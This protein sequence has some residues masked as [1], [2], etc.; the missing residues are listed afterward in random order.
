MGGSIFMWFRF[1]LTLVCSLQPLLIRLL[2]RPPLTARLGDE[3][4]ADELPDTLEKCFD[5]THIVVFISFYFC[6]SL[7]M[8]SLLQRCRVATRV[9]EARA[10]SEPM[11][12]RTQCHARMSIVEEEDEDSMLQLCL[13]R[14]NTTVGQY[15][16]YQ[17]SC[18]SDFRAF[19]SPTR[20]VQP[21]KRQHHAPKPPAASFLS[22]WLF[23]SREEI[24]LNASL[25]SYP[26]SLKYSL[27]L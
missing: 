23:S 26:F 1:L 14:R 6:L 3:Q 12:E 21:L 5:L 24:R 4:V 18:P 13:A 2:F 27:P 20:I 25:A 11:H 7:S 10:A 8:Q 15:I 16:A 9:N 19:R 17:S 22:Y